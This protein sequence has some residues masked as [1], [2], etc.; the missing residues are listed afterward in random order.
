MNNI[1]IDL[2]GDEFTCRSYYNSDSDQGIE[3]KKGKK[4]IGAIQGL[5]IPDENGDD[6]QKDLAYFTK[7]VEI[8]LDEKYY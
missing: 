3:V 8:L 5:N 7:E 4:L 6:Y 1:K 2:G